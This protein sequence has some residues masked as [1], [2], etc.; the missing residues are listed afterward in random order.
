MAARVPPDPKSGVRSA[1]RCTASASAEFPSFSATLP[2]KG[3]WGDLYVNV[4]GDITDP[5]GS[6][7]WNMYLCVQPGDG[8][9]NLPM[10]A[11]FTFGLVKPGGA[12]A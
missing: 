4:N 10:W 1:S 11:A 5:T 2:I 9:G 12:S 3:Q 8:P 7:V 6:I